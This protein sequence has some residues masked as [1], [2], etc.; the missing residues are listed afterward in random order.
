MHP[1]IHGHP[2]LTYVFFQQH[3]I[4]YY[5][6]WSTVVVYGPTWALSGH[7]Q[8]R[9]AA[10]SGLDKVNYKLELNKRIHAM[11]AIQLLF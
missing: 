9:Q 1:S 6:V 8:A 11:H 3:L 4:V 5:T 7:C 10:L 2:F